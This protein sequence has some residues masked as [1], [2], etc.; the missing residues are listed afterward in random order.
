MFATDK[1]LKDVRS[2]FDL[3]AKVALVTGGGSGLGRGIAE[4]FAQFG[5]RIAVVDY[6]LDTAQET[7]SLV[8]QCGGRAMAIQ[9][10]VSKE[11]QA[12]EAVAQTVQEFGQIDI[13][14]AIA[15]IG[16]RNPAEKM[17]LEQWDRVIDINLKGVWLFDQEVGKHMIA[18]GEGG[19]LINM[20]SIAGIVGLTT[21]N[22]N[23][24]A[25][26]GGVIALTRLLAIEWA[27]YNIRVNSI[28]PVQFKTPLIKDL[29]QKKPETE[30]YF[31]SHIPLGRLGEVEEMVGP[32]VFLA[33]NAASMVTGHTLVVDGGS[34]VC[35]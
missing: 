10:D 25:S 35:F 31:I 20:A 2:I 3:S 30:D 5:A 6:N 11:D 29:I 28:A 14:A 32:A 23:Y 7:V 9:C 26:K 4:G 18:R 27:K 12:K 16:D 1:A 24:A 13:L 33:S 17:T 34:T 21:G 8:E 15:G 22:A 19:S